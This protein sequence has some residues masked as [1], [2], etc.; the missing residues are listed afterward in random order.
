[1][2]FVNPELNSIKRANKI[3]RRKALGMTGAEIA[4]DLHMTIFNVAR[5]YQWLVKHPQYIE[6]EVKNCED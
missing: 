4:A 2:S 1:M 3:L 5:W 6:R